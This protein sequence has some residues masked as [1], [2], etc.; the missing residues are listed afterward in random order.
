VLDGLRND[1]TIATSDDAHLLWVGVTEEG[2]VRDSFLVGELITV[3]DLDDAI[4]NQHGA[5]G[6]GG[7]NHHA[8]QFWNNIKSNTMIIT[9]SIKAT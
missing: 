8:L 7:G 4:D 5:I 3:S 1:T 2:D 6:L 9:G